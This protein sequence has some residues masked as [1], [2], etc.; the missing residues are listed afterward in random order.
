MEKE[1]GYADVAHDD[2]QTI[3]V[4]H[5]RIETRRSC[6]ISAP[7]ILTCMNPD[8]AWSQ[9]QSLVMVEAKRQL[10]ERPSQET[11]YFNSS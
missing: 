4:D 2:H 7:E 1:N 9:L 6:A 5:V 8:Q 11:R 10:A 3:E